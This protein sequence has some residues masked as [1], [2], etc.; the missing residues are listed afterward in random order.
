M[1][2]DRLAPEAPV[3]T[4]SPMTLR[5]HFL[6][7]VFRLFSRYLKDRIEG[8]ENLPPKGEGYIAAAN[9]RSFVD[10]LILP[11]VLVTARAEP[12]H[13]VSYAYLFRIPVIRVILRW[14]EGLVLDPGTKEGIDRFFRDA[15]RALVE[16]HECVGLHPEAHIQR[17]TSRLG[18]G[19]PGA[20]QLA[21]ETGCPV[22]PVALFGTAV[23]MPPG[24]MK[25]HYRRRAISMKVGRPIYLTR[26]RKAYL[27]GD[28]RAKLD[29]LTGCTTLI[30]REI[31]RLT[32]QPYP[33][34]A[35]AFGR[36]G[37]YED[38]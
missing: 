18:K 13:M 7:V 16:K 14:A 22:V 27:E 11:Q 9:H 28:R 29:I 12:V 15:K 4:L 23:V 6:E 35:R 2:P 5:Y 38:A 24:G 37:R 8:L 36:L 17:D 21:I 10:G 20:A 32:G 34:G 25:L 3:P 33:F 26:Y 19:R 31:G 30:M 1:A